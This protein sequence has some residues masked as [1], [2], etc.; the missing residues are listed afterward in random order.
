MIK[1]KYY[2]LKL[3]SRGAFYFDGRLCNMIPAYRVAAVDTTAA[4][5]A[6]TSAL[7]VRYC[8]TGNIEASIRFACAVGALTVTKCGASR[9][10]PTREETEAFIASNPAI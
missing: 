9:S 6:F 8:E 7:A 3:G 1:A 2:V 5:D 4:G 10:I